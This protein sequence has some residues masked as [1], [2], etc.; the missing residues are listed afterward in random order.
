MQRVSQS[1]CSTFKIRKYENLI[2]KA[3]MYWNSQMAKLCF[4]I[5]ILTNQ[6]I[7]ANLLITPDHKK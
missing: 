4:P 5:A 6:R 2:K 1:N 3:D 7:R